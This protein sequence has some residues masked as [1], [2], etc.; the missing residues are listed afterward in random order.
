[1]QNTHAHKTNAIHLLFG[2]VSLTF[3]TAH[4]GNVGAGFKSLLLAHSLELLVSFNTKI[5]EN[6]GTPKV[7]Q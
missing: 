3:C 4:V 7:E 5:C 6:V 2:N 1:M